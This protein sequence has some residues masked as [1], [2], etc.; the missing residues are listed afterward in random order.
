MLPRQDDNRG[1]IT[2]LHGEGP[3]RGAMAGA[4]VFT[5]FSCRNGSCDLSEA[6]AWRVA[7]GSPHRFHLAGGQGPD[8]CR[9]QGQPAGQ[10]P[11]SPVSC[12]PRST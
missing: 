6:V 12:D 9:L 5:L 4:F 3:R 2:H 1:S 8:R 11:V 7:R 10:F